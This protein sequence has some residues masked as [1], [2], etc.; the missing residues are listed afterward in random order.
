MFCISCKVQNYFVHDMFDN[1]CHYSAPKLDHLQ[2]HSV[3]AQY[4][5]QT[6]HKSNNR[7][8]VYQINIL[9]IINKI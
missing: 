5:I 7:S 3:S 6:T 9:I 4:Y 2:N 1:I 8:K